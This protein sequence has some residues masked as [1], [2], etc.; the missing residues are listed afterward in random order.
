MCG[1]CV[2]VLFGNSEPHFPPVLSFTGWG[3]VCQIMPKPV[4]TCHLDE[5][6]PN[7]KADMNGAE[8]ALVNKFWSIYQP[9][10]C[11]F[12]GSLA[13]NDVWVCTQLPVC[14][15]MGCG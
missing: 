1:V 11:S 14:R 4:H 13:G 12:L 2:R 15:C 5:H 8:T 6:T 7:S 3:P 9:G 10:T